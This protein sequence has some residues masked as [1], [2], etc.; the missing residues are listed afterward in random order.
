MK[1]GFAVVWQRLAELASAEA[2]PDTEQ[3]RNVA[4][5]ARVPL[6]SHVFLVSSRICQFALAVVADISLSLRL[7]EG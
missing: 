2:S 5:A 1:A 4:V 6:G 3:R 7:D